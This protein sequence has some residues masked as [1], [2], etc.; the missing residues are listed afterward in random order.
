MFDPAG[1]H[2]PVRARGCKHDGIPNIISPQSRIG[3]DDHHI[4]D[5]CFNFEYRITRWVLF[6]ET[7]RWNK[8]VI[9][10]GIKLK[11]HPLFLLAVL[12]SKKPFAG[13]IKLDTIDRSTDE[14]F[15]L[16][17]VGL[18]IDPSIDEE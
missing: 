3:R 18:I 2:N 9:N 13:R 16:F 14:A 15:Q 6:K 11:Q 10:T 12:E 1:Y 7:I 5:P 17:T 8:L 4:V